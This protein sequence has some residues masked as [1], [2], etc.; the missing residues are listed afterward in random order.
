MASK[1][2]STD[3]FERLRSY[4][5]PSPG[6]NGN[7][8]ME[9]V[10]HDGLE[11][12]S[13]GS[14]DLSPEPVL[15][16]DTNP[17]PATSSL[18]S[19][20]THKDSK[21]TSKRR[22]SHSSRKKD[23]S[24]RL[25][26]NKSDQS[27]PKSGQKSKRSSEGKSS[28]RRKNSRSPNS[29]HRA[30]RKKHHRSP[31]PDLVK[32]SNKKDGHHGNNSRMLPKCY[33]QDA[34]E[35]A[36]QHSPNDCS[37]HTDKRHQYNDHVTHY[38]SVTPTSTDDEYVS[39]YDY[40]RRGGVKSRSPEYS[41]RLTYRRNISRSP[42]P[43]SYRRDYTPPTKRGYSRSPRRRRES[44]P[45]RHY[46]PGPPHSSGMS[47]RRG[48]VYRRTPPRQISRYRRSPISP[49]G[50]RSPMSPR[51]GRTPSRSPRRWNYSRS[52]PTYHRGQKFGT[53]LD[54][55]SSSPVREIVRRSRTPVNRKTSDTTNKGTKRTGPKT[56]PPAPLNDEEQ[57]IKDSVDRKSSSDNAQP[58]LPSQ[59]VSKTSSG[60]DAPLP[61]TPPE[62]LPPLPSQ[63]PPPPPP[64][65]LPPPPP[66]PHPP[67][68]ITS[69]FSSLSST[70]FQDTPSNGSSSKPIT[71]PP[72]VPLLFK[73][74]KITFQ[75]LLPELTAIVKSD[76]IP[77]P[78]E[79]TALRQAHRCIEA[80]ETLA[81]V[82]EGTYGQVY[83][84]RDLK[85]N[86]IV[87][88][89]KV[90]TDHEHEREGFPITALREIK[91]LRQL[92]HE[93]IV[94]LKEIISDKP[95]ASQLKKD[96]GITNLH[97]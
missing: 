87:A 43:H 51:G 84:A 28:K 40:R 72:P 90:R 13:S 6:S 20:T 96:K 30:K 93:N 95:Y 26:H 3:A 94:N 10:S 75:P 33:Q 2:D 83:K 36:N 68:I 60:V 42:P 9:P 47:P 49:R 39:D 15:P 85:T 76:A 52:P 64:E 55:N 31:S 41:R 78:P 65:D 69:S 22:S 89:K 91:I 79:L 86:E 77:T 27:R 54:Q 1:N 45:S 82:G 71:P 7:P 12:I 56:P 18:P 32:H 88:L 24:K 63:E 19:K 17:V 35:K 8:V 46:S 44:P 80:F 92:R 53:R 11:S 50:R 37:A 73:Q 4:S 97:V 66:I 81:Q 62:G 21:K 23:K 34:D 48:R 29:H 14:K 57:Q 58:P 61:P 5:T 67:C 74:E 70:P 59:S 25:S 38:D 16:Y